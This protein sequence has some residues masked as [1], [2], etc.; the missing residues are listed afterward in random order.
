MKVKFKAWDTKQKKW[1][2]FGLFEVNPH[3]EEYFENICQFTGLRD[4]NDQEIYEGD[5]LQVGEP[6]QGCEK[7]GHGGGK[8]TY[9]AVKRNDRGEFVTHDSNFS[10]HTMINYGYEKDYKIVGNIYENPEL[11]KS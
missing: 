10:I 11:I 6:K 2:Y 4:A 5:I 8:I 7:C 1:H 3:W 9:V